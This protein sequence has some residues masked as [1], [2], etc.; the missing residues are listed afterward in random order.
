[1]IAGTARPLTRRVLIVDDKLSGTIT[2]GGRAIRTLVDELRE[3]GIEVVEALSVA[4]G[5]AHVVSD[6]ALHGVFLSWTIGKENG[7]GRGQ[8]RTH[9]EATTLLRT[10]RARNAKVPVF[11]M[12][13][14][15]ITGT[16]TVEVATLVDEFIWI[17][18]DTAAFI[19]GRASAA[20]ERYI[21]ALLPPLATGVAR[22]DRDRE[23]S[24][25]R[26]GHQGR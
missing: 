12:A 13:D 23:A 15:S 18:E 21:Q 5:Q 3:R 25:A 14:R 17:L 19:G 26:A 22:Q 2:A 6:A 16:V 8:S 7:N 1:M 9:K 11:L 24:T 10:L 4:D 20:I